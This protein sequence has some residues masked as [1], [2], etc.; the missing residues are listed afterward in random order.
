M[1]TLMFYSY[2]GGSGR[3]VAAAN[4]AAALTQ[5]GKR[6]A[7]I[8]LDFEAPGLQHVLSA[9]GT[10]QFKSGTGVQHYLKSEVDLHELVNEVAIDVFAKD[11]PLFKYDV[12]D[13]ALLIYI[14]AS[15]KVTRVDAQ[16]P[17]V[18]A[19]M[20]NLVGRLKDVYNLDYLVIDAA[21][22]IRETYSLAADVSDEML[23]FFRWSKQHV[24]GTLR[25]VRFM[26]R[27]KEFDQSWVPFKLVASAS[28]SQRELDALPDDDLRKQLMSIKNNTQLR[29]EK[30]LTEC[31]V[32]PTTI[33]HE[34][35]EMLELKWRET[36]TVF[37]DDDSPYE[38][39][40]RKLLESDT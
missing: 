10:A 21:S 4:V 22:G 32:S 35:P 7:I 25:L 34:I 36:I 13:G 29:I 6:V 12:P 37:G 11:G 38:A 23:V 2:K 19:L 17:R 24:E 18:P 5:L 1:K 30:E 39:L 3:T 9:E 33:F 14:M 16:E 8:D 28:P 20:K 15:T 26:S 27:L 40:A 31:Q